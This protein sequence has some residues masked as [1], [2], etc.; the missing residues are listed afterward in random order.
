MKRLGRPK[1]LRPLE[2]QASAEERKM[3][4]ALCRFFGLKTRAKILQYMLMYVVLDIANT[5]ENPDW[6]EQQK[7]AWLHCRQAANEMRQTVVLTAAKKVLAEQ[8]PDKEMTLIEL[9]KLTKTELCQIAEAKNIT[10]TD[11]RKSGLIKRIH[12]AGG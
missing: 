5:P 9:R 1:K 7:D 12:Q 11:L 6:T 4:D 3:I 10:T 2:I 8:S